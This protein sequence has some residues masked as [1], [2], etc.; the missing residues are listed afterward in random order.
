M[1]KIRII[2]TTLRDGEQA[3]GVVFSRSDK[4]EIASLLT[5]AGVPELEVGIP[6]M[7]QEERDD[8]KSIVAMNLAARLTCWCRAI[9]TDIKDAVKC[10]VNSVHISFP[11]SDILMSVF[12]T[13]KDQV[14]EDL[15]KIS[16]YALDHFEYVSVGAQDATRAHRA[17]LRLFCETAVQ[18]GIH[19]VRIADTVGHANPMQVYDLIAYLQKQASDEILEFHGHNDL[20]MATANTIAAISAGAGS[21]SVTVN[22]LGERAGN[23]AL[24]E[25]VMATRHT[26]NIECDIDTKFFLSLSGLV[27]KA[28]GRELQESKPVVG[29]SAFLH[30]SG[31]HV[32]GLIH[33]RRSYELFPAEDIGAKTPDFIVGKHSG[34]ATVRQ[35]LL[36]KGVTVNEQISREMLNRIKIH[37]RQKRRRLS[38]Q[39][40]TNIYDQTVTRA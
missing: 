34:R 2:D 1:R 8:I 5:R 28:S 22:G 11:V 4:R 20:G 25:V 16:R 13:G 36:K 19:R 6:A 21:V 3:A 30:E 33:N 27:E 32:R 26:L 14:L 37:A 40:V 9:Q 39:E 23:A 7:G 24:E 35:F 17:F 31:I 10:R 12:K 15:K 38:F 29:R 18:S